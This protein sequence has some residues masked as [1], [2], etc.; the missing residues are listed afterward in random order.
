MFGAAM[1]GVGVAVVVA[2][3]EERVWEKGIGKG[4]VV[5]KG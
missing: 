4:S 2:S 1:V 5:V 3:G